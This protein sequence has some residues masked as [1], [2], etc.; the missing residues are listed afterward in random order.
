MLRMAKCAIITLKEVPLKRLGM[1]GLPN[2]YEFSEK[3]QTGFGDLAYQVSSLSSSKH[4]T[5][6]SPEIL[7]QIV[8]Y[9]LFCLPQIYSYPATLLSVSSTIMH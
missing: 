2:L 8:C 7:D 3:L 6:M 5:K 1:I 9:S 4:Q